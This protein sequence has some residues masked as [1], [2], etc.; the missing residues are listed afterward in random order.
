MAQGC[1]N[2]RARLFEPFY[3]TKQHGAGTGLGLSI[4]KSIVERHGGEISVE[5]TAQL[6]TRVMVELPCRPSTPPGPL[7]GQG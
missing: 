4:V 2:G 5:S 3:S 6:G 1:R 7:D